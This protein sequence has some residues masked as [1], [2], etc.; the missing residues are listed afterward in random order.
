MADLTGQE[1]E[2]LEVDATIT[3]TVEVS[4]TQDV[5]LI[6][7]NGDG[8]VVD[9]KNI[10]LDE[11]QDESDTWAWQTEEGDEG[12]YTATIQSKDDSDS[13]TV[14]VTGDEDAPS[15]VTE[16][17]IRWYDATEQDDA[18]TLVDQSPNEEDATAVG[19]PTLTTVDGLD[20][21]ELDGTSDAYELI[22]SLQSINEYHMF[23]VMVA[24]RGDDNDTLTYFRENN[25]WFTRFRDDRYSIRQNGDSDFIQS[26]TITEGERKI[27]EVAYDGSVAEIGYN[28]EFHDSSS[29]G[30]DEPNPGRDGIG[31]DVENTRRFVD[32][33]IHELILIP[34]YQSGSDRGE[35]N[36]YLADK[37]DIT[38]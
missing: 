38:I 13:I 29:I 5:D 7:E 6:I 35:I 12:T 17:S 21:I 23:I 3:N 14:E 31:A 28:A 22:N 11:S 2:T 24:N 25:E 8:E 19:S 20:A 4:D 10:L 27:Y 37:W 36:D 9:S 34:E 32:G 16:D 18:D 30:F 1:G 33:Y 15:S 26:D